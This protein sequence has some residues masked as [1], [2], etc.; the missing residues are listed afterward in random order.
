MFNSK[1]RG[2]IGIRAERRA[3]TGLMHGGGAFGQ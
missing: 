1:I 2:M 3:G